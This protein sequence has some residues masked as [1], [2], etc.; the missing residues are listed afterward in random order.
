[1]I[2]AI[3][4]ECLHD[5]AMLLGTVVRHPPLPLLLSTPLRVT[6]PP[7]PIPDVPRVVRRL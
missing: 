7:P 4:M 6:G 2:L 1:M 3:G 5:N